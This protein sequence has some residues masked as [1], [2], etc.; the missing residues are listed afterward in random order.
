MLWTPLA[1]VVAS[2]FVFTHV[3]R[4]RTGI[5][6][7]VWLTMAI[8]LYW[9][10]G[11]TLPDGIG[12]Q[13]AWVWLILGIELLAFAD[14]IIL[15]IL[16]S[17]PRC[18]SVAATAQEEKLRRQPQANLPSVDVFITTYDEQREV[19]EKTIVG[20]LAMD[21][22]DAR[23]WVLDDGRRAWLRDLC[24]DNGAG[25]ITRPDN[26]GAKAGNINHA[27]VHT[28][29]NLVMVLDADF[30]PQRNFLWRTVGFFEDPTVG[31]VQVPHS[32]YNSD[33]LQHNLGLRAALPDDQ[34]F[35]FETI[36]PGRDGWNTAFCCGSNSITRRSLF[37]SIGGQLP[38]G[39][40]TEDM[41]LTIAALR[42]GFVTRYLNEPLAFGL[43]P[44]SVSA[45][46]VQRQR[47]AQGGIQILHLRE[48]PLGHGLSLIARLAFL[49]THYLT[50]SLAALFAVLSPIIFLWTGIA[51]LVGVT[52]EAVIAYLV[53]MVVAALGGLACLAPGRYIPLASQVLNL[54]Q[55]FRILP[56]ALLT[57]VKP[58]GHDFR[59]TPKGRAAT[60]GA[61][62]AI[63]VAGLALVL[64]TIGG[65]LV[66][67]RPD[68]RIVEQAALVP[69][70]AI[71]CSLNIAI[72]LLMCMLCLQ[73]PVRR[74]E[75]RLPLSDGFVLQGMDSVALPL[76]A[77]ADVSLSGLGAQ[78][79]EPHGLS[80]G[81]LVCLQLDQVGGITGRVVYS[82]SHRVGVRFNPMDD[83][84]RNRLIVALYATRPLPATEAAGLWV[85]TLAILTRIRH[86]NLTTYSIHPSLEPEAETDQ[87]RLP[88]ATYILQPSLGAW[89]YEGMMM[90]RHNGPLSS[91]DT[92][93]ATVPT[94]ETT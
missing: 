14:A 28:H 33:P 79:A 69:M 85:T 52:V 56:V 82:S 45:F 17:R 34:R 36:M 38:E 49:P 44:E 46:F 53:P 70:V 94:L 35:F 47:W 75:E 26:R 71:W 2:L 6:G 10:I 13:Q 20:A 31:I 92:R 48:G 86:A 51:P 55:A 57:L 80:N 63:C 89:W 1:L 29:A 67:S 21:W 77:K 15:H 83:A 93:S 81:A 78:F 41:L 68:H 32:F 23:I 11:T 91:N 50:Q 74:L 7:T 43:A 39:S 40:I 84:M 30:I 72:L 59:V 19:I 9:R 90:G 60:S 58:R 42:K 18:N 22:P 5:I 73:V 27:L 54:F 88:V 37:E 64:L 8:Y 65:L 66:N 4:S 12:M 87:R 61:D 62:L 16:L 76:P 25:Y 24:A 3:V